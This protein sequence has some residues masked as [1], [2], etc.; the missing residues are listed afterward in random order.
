[1]VE[2]EVGQYY[3]YSPSNTLIKIEK[4]VENFK[5]TRYIYSSERRYTSRG[6]YKGMEIHR[7]LIH[8]SQEILPLFLSLYS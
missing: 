1:M 2:I 6:F 7:N 4:I 3:L 8:I 5:H